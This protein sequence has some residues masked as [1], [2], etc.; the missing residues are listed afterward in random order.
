MKHVRMLMIV[1]GMLLVGLGGNGCNNDNDSSTSS[2]PLD[3]RGTYR[4]EGTITPVSG[5][6]SSLP[7]TNT[8]TISFA[9]SS[10]DNF[11][12]SACVF[13]NGILCIPTS[14]VGKIEGQQFTMQD[15]G[16][17]A[18]GVERHLKVTGKTANASNFT[19]SGQGS[20]EP[21]TCVF[22]VTGTLTKM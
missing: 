21:G 18:N 19:L 5:D 4:S 16:V 2:F 20:K 17:L 14:F 7:S 6:C 1:V 15:D 9:Q 3:L 10:S 11:T 12:I 8:G 22:E 13:D